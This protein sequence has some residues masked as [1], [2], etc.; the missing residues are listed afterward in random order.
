MSTVTSCRIQVVADLSTKLATKLTISET[1][2]F[3]ADLSLVSATVDFVA[4]VT[5]QAVSVR[6]WSVVNASS[7]ETVLCWW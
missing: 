7:S 4:G 3:I 5:H 2:G 6:L 1:V